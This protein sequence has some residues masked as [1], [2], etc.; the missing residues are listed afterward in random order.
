M[1]DREQLRANRLQRNGPI[2]PE[3]IANNFFLRHRESPAGLP[4]RATACRR[5]EPLFLAVNQSGDLRAVRE[6]FRQRQ[7]QRSLFP[8]RSP[9]TG[10]LCDREDKRK[11]PRWRPTSTASR[12]HLPLLVFR[13]PPQR[14]PS[15][16][17]SSAIDR[18]IQHFAV[19]TQPRKARRAAVVRPVSF[20][21]EKQQPRCP[22]A[23]NQ[24]HTSS[25]QA[26]VKPSLFES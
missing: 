15:E 11:T 16:D 1:A 20:L 10:H 6:L 22:A 8:P 4:P 19:S 24:R 7:R 25:G 2:F 3:P 9:T 14:A 23:N 12:R 5:R 21:F 13:L 26:T 17:F 18:P